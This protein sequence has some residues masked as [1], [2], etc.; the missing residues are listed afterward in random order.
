MTGSSTLEDGDEMQRDGS[1][2]LSLA[3]N[4]GNVAAA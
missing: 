3:S 1:R 2:L 4:L